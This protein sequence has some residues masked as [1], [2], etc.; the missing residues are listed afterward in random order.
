MSYGTSILGLGSY[1][2]EDIYDNFY[3]EQYVETTDEWIRTRTGIRERRFVRDGMATSDIATLA[4]QEALKESNLKADEIDLIIVATATP[5]RLF[6]STAC[7]V[8]EKLRA[9]KAAAF[10]IS[11]GCSGFIYALACASQFMENGLFQ[12]VLVIG[13]ETL[14]KFIDMKDR[15]T[16]VLMGDGAGALVLE[17]TEGENQ[18]LSFYLGADGTGGQYLELPAG[19]S[20]LPASLETVEKKLH[21]IKMEGSLVFKWAVEKMVLSGLEATRR[22][23]L[24]LKEIDWLLPHQANIR[25]IQSVASRLGFPME[26]VLLSLETIGN[27][28]AASIPLTLSQSL[29]EGKIK[30]GDLL[31]LLGFGAGFTW[32]G[33]VLRWSRGKNERE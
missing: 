5:D 20:H 14:S 16:C 9:K 7:T 33:A 25:I 15:T 22:A 2:P 28:S 31:L 32:G 8:Q 10:D 4:A 17:R 21:Y 26:K 18:L 3:F 23:G 29:R 1:L 12:R 19:G 24:N 11:A 6:P 13:A 27:T 30:D